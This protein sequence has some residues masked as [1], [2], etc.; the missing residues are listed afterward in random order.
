MKGQARVLRPDRAQLQWD[1]VDLEGLLS[2]DHRARMVWAFVESL[3]LTAFYD[4]VAAREGEPGRPPA[5]PAVLL[6]LWLYA[7]LEGVGSARELDRLCE[8]D[9]AYRWLCG[10]VP[11]NYHGLSDFR[12]GHGDLL[13]RLLS[14]S[15]AALIA[16]GLVDL[17]EVTIDGTKVRA[18]A[19]K[20]SF[21]GAEGLARAERVASERVAR[22][23]AEVDT[24]AGASARR[25]RAAAERAAREI[26]ARA[27]KARAMLDR[28][29]AEKQE[30]AK[31][32][33][34]EE[35]AK[36]EPRVSLTDPEARWM[37]FADG[38][39]RAGY[40]MPIAATDKGIVL[41]VM[42]SHRRNDA[43]LAMPMIDDIE[44]R[45]GRAPKR[46]LLDTNLAPADD[47]VALAERKPSAVI[48]YA[49]PPRQRDDVKPDTLRRRAAAR[50]KEPQPLKEWRDRMASPQAQIIYRA[51]RRI[52][53]VNAHIK[54]RGFGQLSLR[55][56]ANAKIIAL[57]HA[58]AHNILV[59]ARLRF[60][61]P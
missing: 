51:R 48:V 12:A 42:A 14:E 56:L 53:L 36:G 34:K 30:R 26:A 16:E 50:A 60:A 40:N 20:R 45:Y 9:V 41:S 22:L 19:G 28:L 2:V 49:P 33:V 27:Q 18:S 23:K 38:M 32:H 44:R 57:W 43:G 17:D 61:V 11:V 31:K 21:V 10:G 13:D 35:Q 8:R 5:D 15:V 37:R 47:I 24:D 3:E 58:L 54:N 6:A 59:A 52:E 25:K 29:T 1:M 7:T 55:G 4:L 46:A 39:I